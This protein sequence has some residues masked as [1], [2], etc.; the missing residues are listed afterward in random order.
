MMFKIIHLDFYFCIYSC[1]RHL[2]SSEALTPQIKKSLFSCSYNGNLKICRLSNRLYPVT[3]PTWHKSHYYLATFVTDFVH[4]GTACCCCP[5]NWMHQ[6]LSFLGVEN[7]SCLGWTSPAV[8]VIF[9]GCHSPFLLYYGG[10]CCCAEGQNPLILGF[11]MCDASQTW[12]L[13]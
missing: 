5:E 10:C 9:L 1:S 13:N 7:E 8:Q 3:K 6:S 11:F 2:G 4:C 12:N